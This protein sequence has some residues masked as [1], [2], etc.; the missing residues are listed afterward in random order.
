MDEGWALGIKDEA[1]T[2]VDTVTSVGH[3][4]ISAAE[5]ALNS[6]SLSYGI[7]AIA[8]DTKFKMELWCTVLLVPL[9]VGCGI[10]V[11]YLKTW[12]VGPNQSI[13]EVDQNLKRLCYYSLIC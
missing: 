13:L 3:N 2:V 5:R 8:D 1:G 7:N 11:R 10:N 12:I 6:Q 4:V 9:N